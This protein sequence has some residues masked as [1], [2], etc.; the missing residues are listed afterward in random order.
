MCLSIKSLLLFRARPRAFVYSYAAAD[1]LFTFKDAPGSMLFILEVTFE[2][3]LCIIIHDSDR[4]G[5]HVLDELIVL[6][7]IAS[8]FFNQLIS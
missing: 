8:I 2:S 6:L 7:Q 4:N 1:A 5:R 3:S